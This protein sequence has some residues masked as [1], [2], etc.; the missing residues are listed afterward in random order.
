MARA[1]DPIKTGPKTRAG[2][3][4]RRI[5]GPMLVRAG[6]GAV[7]EVPGRRTGTP[8]RVSLVP[9]DVDGTWYLLSTYGISDWVRNLRASGHGV[10]RRKGEVQP[11]T[12]IEVHGEERDRVVARYRARAPG[13][14]QRDYDLRGDAADHPAFRIEPLP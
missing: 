3:I 9:Q 10:L 8:L 5:V 11:F 14:F 1:R 6:V 7:L 13:A 2:P 4:V 12:A